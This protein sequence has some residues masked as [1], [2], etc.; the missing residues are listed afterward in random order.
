MG[1]E[2]QRTNFGQRNIIERASH[3]F[4]LRYSSQSISLILLY[5]FLSKIHAFGF[6]Q[7]IS[8]SPFKIYSGKSLIDSL[9]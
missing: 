8:S 2:V 5:I 4:F 1:I 7:R 6:G 9:Y 3:D